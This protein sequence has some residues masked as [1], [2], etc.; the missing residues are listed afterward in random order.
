MPLEPRLSRV[1]VLAETE[2]DATLSGIDLVETREP[3]DAGER[4][5]RGADDTGA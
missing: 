2:H 5:D 1:Y 3:P 4:D